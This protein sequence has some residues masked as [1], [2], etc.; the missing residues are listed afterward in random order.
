MSEFLPGVGPVHEQHTQITIPSLDEAAVPEKPIPPLTPEQ[1]RAL[2]AALARDQESANVAG[3]IGLWTGSMLLK[4]LAK[5][6]FSPP[7]DDRPIEERQKG[8]PEEEE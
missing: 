1:I 2:D 8:K 3:L 7:A 5:E 6:H 4:D